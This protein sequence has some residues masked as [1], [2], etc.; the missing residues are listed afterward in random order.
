[1]LKKVCYTLV[2]ILIIQNVSAQNISGKVSDKNNEPLIGASVYWL[3]TTTGTVTNTKGEFEIA[4]S[5][6]TNKLVV[7]FVGFQ[8]DTISVVNNKYI[9]V[10]LTQDES[11]KEVVIE[12][13]RAGE[14]GRAH[15]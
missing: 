8:A 6:N 13:E 9:N 11:L 5:E 10:K 14:I 15:V 12:G 1:M 7:S 4:L 3:H 2:C